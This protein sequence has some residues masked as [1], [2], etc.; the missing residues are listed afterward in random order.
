MQSS[1]TAQSRGRNIKAV[2]VA[3]FAEIAKIVAKTTLRI[4]QIVRR[5]LRAHVSHVL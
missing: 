4:T 2:D 1:L 5:E 3:D